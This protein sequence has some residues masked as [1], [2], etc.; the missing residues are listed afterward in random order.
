[1]KK[2]YIVNY[3]KTDRSRNVQTVVVKAKSWDEAIEKADEEV[4]G[5]Y[6]VG[7]I[8]VMSL[9]EAKR[10]SLLSNPMKRKT[11]C[12]KGYKPVKGKRPY[13][14]GSCRRINRRRG[15][16]RIVGN[17]S[18]YSKTIL[19]VLKSPIEAYS[20]GKRI[21]DLYEALL[22]R[23]GSGELG[24][25][26]GWRNRNGELV[27]TPG[28][29]TLDSLK[30]VSDSIA[31]DYGQGWTVRGMHSAIA[32]AKSDALYRIRDLKGNPMT[33]LQFMNRLMANPRLGKYEKKALDFARKYPGWHGFDPRKPT[34]NIV[35]RLEKKGLVKVSDI[36]NQFRAI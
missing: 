16:R 27:Q 25:M 5:F 7:E 1:M 21:P 24:I 13:S 31:I 9:A 11:R 6:D 28:A 23:F 35:R 3:L 32:E 30:G 10:K 19:K 2:A 20:R 15:L 17:P 29:W 4:G 26:I 18:R 8:D 36:S 33:K 14:K 22:I 12:W 34:A